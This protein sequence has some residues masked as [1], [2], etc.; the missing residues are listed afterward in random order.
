M[1]EKIKKRD[2]SHE[3]QICI[4]GPSKERTVIPR[5]GNYENQKLNAHWD[6][7]IFVFIKTDH[8]D[9]NFLKRVYYI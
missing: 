1:K 2:G 5:K 8:G 9:I 7:Q 4:G 6:S 3:I